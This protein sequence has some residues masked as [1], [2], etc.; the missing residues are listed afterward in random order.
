[1][2]LEPLLLTLLY[3]LALVAV[4]GAIN[5]RDTVRMVISSLLAM[6]CLAAAVYHTSRYL[7]L[8]EAAAAAAEAPA[9]EP[10]PPP[11]PGPD[12]A[13][14]GASQQQA[15]LAEA[16]AKLRGVLEMAE[17]LRQN[18]SGFDLTRVTEISDEEYQRMQGR[19]QALSA[20]ARRLKERVDETTPQLPGGLEGAVEA[21]N[22]AVEG[23]T[24]GSHNLERFFKSENDTEE[25]ERRGA[26]RQGVQNAEAALRKVE[27]RLGSS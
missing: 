4:I 24:T 13:G 1:M 20:E 17:R 14:L 25:R 8:Q 5:S 9:P 6:L 11:P 18:L 10:P 23:L 26:F 19:A 16:R 3:A 15:A 12:P 21:L 27:S 2:S 22:T 7:T